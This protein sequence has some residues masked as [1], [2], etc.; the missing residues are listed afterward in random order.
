MTERHCMQRVFLRMRSGRCQTGLTMVELLVALALAALLMAAM[1][2]LLQ[3][4]R[5]PLQHAE[6]TAR[7]AWP[8]RLAA[9]IRQDLLAASGVHAQNETVWITGQ[10][11]SASR[12]GASTSFVGYA[13]MP[14]ER[15]NWALVRIDKDG[16]E[17]FAY[18]PSRLLVERIDD[19]GVPQPLPP[20]IG[21]VPN[22]VRLWV[23]GAGANQP[24]VVRDIVLW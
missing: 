3:S 8:G 4:L 21:P 1:T 20:T 11:R 14:I 19:L 18:G 24:E 15:E 5:L 9:Q 16:F 13:C 2:S 10:L 7:P 22:R 6:R 23:F 12:P 17:V